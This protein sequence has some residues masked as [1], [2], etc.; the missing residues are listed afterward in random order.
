M[1]FT[2]DELIYMGTQLLGRLATEG[3]DGTLQV[4]PVGFRYNSAL[5]TI[6]V[7]G[8]NMGSSKKFRNVQANAR[9][10]FVVDDIYSTDPWMVRCV[11]VRGYAEALEEPQRS[12]AIVDGPII[13][14]HPQR[15][16]SWGTDIG[17]DE[18]MGSP[19]S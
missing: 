12:A 14:I 8:R 9:V 2:G 10:A 16:I 18:E 13:R 11:E 5:D 15:V 6:D 1:K 19:N 7:G 3:P 17:L 4:S